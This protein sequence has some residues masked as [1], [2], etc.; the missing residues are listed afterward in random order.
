MSWV[1]ISIRSVL[2]AVGVLKSESTYDL[3]DVA[4]LAILLV[5]IVFVGVV[6]W[7]CNAAVRRYVSARVEK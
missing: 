2:V 7:F 5:S 6:V 1:I 3:E 4:S